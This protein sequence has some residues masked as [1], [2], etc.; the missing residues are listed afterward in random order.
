MNELKQL[1]NRLQHCRKCPDMC[2]NAVYGPALK[3]KVM[4]IG[5]APGVHEGV[6]GKPFAY[7]AGKTLFKW[8]K[9]SLG[10][11]EEDLRELIYFTAVAR[12]FPGKAAGG[13]GDR[14]PS[15]TEIEKCSPF[16]EAEMKIIKPEVILAVGKLAITEVLKE[17][18]PKDLRL[19]EVVGKVFVAEFHGRKVKVIPL[20]HP[21]GVSRWPHTITGKARLKLA[22]SEISK[23]VSP[24]L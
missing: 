20:P 2:G 13:K 8:L 10:A 6:L 4:L 3:T 14:P 9:E 15:K 24:I 12:C 11:D 17:L 18:S 7:T 19:D 16:L 1:H 5:Q 21:S 22:F 23:I